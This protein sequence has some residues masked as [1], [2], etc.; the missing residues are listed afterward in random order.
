[1]P[2]VL[3][4]PENGKRMAHALGELLL[5]L[6]LAARN[7]FGPPRA[8]NPPSMICLVGLKLILWNAATSL[9]YTIKHSHQGERRLQ[10]YQYCWLL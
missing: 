4:R 5:F 8:N 1:M 6:L 7:W 3:D 9:L 10:Q 2:V